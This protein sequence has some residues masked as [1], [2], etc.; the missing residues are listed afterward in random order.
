MSRRVVTWDLYGWGEIAQALGCSERTAQRYA[1]D[2]DD[3]L[4]VSTF[5]GRV[6]ARTQDVGEWVKRH[7]R[8][9]TAGADAA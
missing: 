4:P 6:R 3:P 1:S 8:H 5:M 7:E 9:N 2:D